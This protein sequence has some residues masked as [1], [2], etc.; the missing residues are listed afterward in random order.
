MWNMLGLNHWFGS[1][2]DRVG[3]IRNEVRGGNVSAAFS[4][5]QYRPLC[6]GLSVDVDE[7]YPDAELCRD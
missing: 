4:I 7:V 1:S 6:Y 5:R 2:D 3:I